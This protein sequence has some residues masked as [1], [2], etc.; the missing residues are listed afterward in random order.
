MGLNMLLQESPEQNSTDYCKKKE[1]SLREFSWSM[2]D[3]T[4]I[5]IYNSRN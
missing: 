5:C 4:T 3:L 1:N 2:V